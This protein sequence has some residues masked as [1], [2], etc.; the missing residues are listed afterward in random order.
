MKAFSVIFNRK[1]SNCPLFPCI[2]IINDGKNRQRYIVP[3]IDMTDD[4]EHAV[5][6]SIDG[7][8]AEY[9]TARERKEMDAMLSRNHYKVSASL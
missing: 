6:A 5:Q 1:C 3:M 7:N 8:W 2:W 9:L 4:L